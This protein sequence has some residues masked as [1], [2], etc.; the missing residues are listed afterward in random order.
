TM[1]DGSTV[2]DTTAPFATTFDTT[3]VP[4]GAGKVFT[5]V[6][7]D[8]KGATAT[9]SVTVSVANNPGGQCINVVFTSTDV[10]KSI[11]DNNAT[12]VIS[13]LPVTGNGVVQSLSLSLNITHTFRGDLV[14]TLISPGGTQFLVSNRAGG[15][16]D[17]IIIT[18]QAVTAF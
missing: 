4:D 8:D 14:V 3:R 10:P 13:A 5:A 15:S 6:A 2:T 16:D 12:G 18:N 17:N 11:P 1:P 7:T 9:S